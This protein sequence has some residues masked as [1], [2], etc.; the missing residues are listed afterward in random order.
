MTK[1]WVAMVSLSVCILVVTAL[2]TFTLPLDANSRPLLTLAKILVG[3]VSVVLAANVVKVVW[4]R[5]L[6]QNLEERRS[7]AAEEKEAPT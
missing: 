4:L 6:E 5:A 3:V 2:I 7:A 1:F